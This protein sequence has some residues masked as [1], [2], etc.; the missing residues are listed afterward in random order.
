MSRERR[1]V[2]F[3]G[4]LR[5]PPR[6]FP[7]SGQLAQRLRQFGL[8]ALGIE[9]GGRWPLSWASMDWMQDAEG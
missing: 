8:C 4:L 3:D 2:R 1:S 6:P 9:A 5:F 7:R